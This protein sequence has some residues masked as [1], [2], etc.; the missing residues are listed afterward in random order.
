MADAETAADPEGTDSASTEETPNTA[1][2]TVWRNLLD[3]FGQLS[4]AWAA[5]RD[6][7]GLAQAGE[8]PAGMGM[9]GD[10]ITSFARAGEGGSEALA[11]LAEVLA[12]QRRSGTTFDQVVETQ[13]QAH[14]EWVRAHHQA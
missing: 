11:G 14:Q 3:A 6:A 9:P 5:A 1:Q 12:H 2:I 8:G 7:Q 13:A 10:L 4:A